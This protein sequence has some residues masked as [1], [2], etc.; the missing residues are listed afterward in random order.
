[1]EAENSNGLGNL[2]D[3][4]AEA[5]GEDEDEET[6]EEPLADSNGFQNGHNESGLDGLETTPRTPHP[7]GE[8]NLSP[9][10]RMP[11]SKYHHRQHSHYDGSDYGD[12]SDFEGINGIS[13]ALEARMAAIEGLA[14]R[15]TES[16]GSDLDDV[17][18]RA[19]NLL[20]DL[21]SQ[22]TIENNAS[23]LI[24]THTALTSHLTNQTQ[25]LSALLHPLI[26]PLSA[27]PDPAYITDLSP[28]LTA[29]LVDLPT[30]FPQ[31][32]SSLHSLH[33]STTELTNLL[34]SLSDSLHMTRQTVS[35]ASRRL[36]TATEMVMEMR[37]ESE[38]EEESVRWLEKGQWERRLAVRECARE[39]GDV[40]GGFE[41][42]CSL[43]RARL[44]GGLEVGVA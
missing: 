31:P 26:S 34:T 38:A 29:L 10:K 41:E 36:R 17:I 19:V 44:I 1:M 27:P 4:L 5:F 20:K 39:C 40:I 8:R 16:N 22:S 21:G 37:R 12:D 32:L 24:T 11:Q 9:P 23:R 28:L 15:G 42:T 43:W 33:S 6:G 35:Q 25:K 18:P 3:E 7:S 14:R 13:P 2:A 30:P